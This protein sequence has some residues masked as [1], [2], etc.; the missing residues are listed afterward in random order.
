MRTKKLESFYLTTYNPFMSGSRTLNSSSTQ[1]AEQQ[2]WN[3]TSAISVQMPRAFK[4]KTTKS[5]LWKTCSRKQHLESLK[6]QR[7]TKNQWGRTQYQLH[8]TVP[9]CTGQTLYPLQGQRR[10][11][12]TKKMQ[13][14]WLGNPSTA[15]EFF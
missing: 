2:L 1:D 3:N 6:W 14:T 12:D 5:L 11:E 13:A 9:T 7:H 8:F 4:H 15:S 10:R